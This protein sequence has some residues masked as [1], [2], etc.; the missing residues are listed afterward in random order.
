MSP[1]SEGKGS[2]FDASFASS[3]EGL[4][5]L[6]IACPSICAQHLLPDSTTHLQTSLCAVRLLGLPRRVLGATLSTDGLSLSARHLED[7]FRWGC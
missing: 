4:P 3:I 1:G 2:K 6:P 7:R 5:G